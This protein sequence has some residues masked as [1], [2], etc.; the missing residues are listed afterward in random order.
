MEECI[1]DYIT[2]HVECEFNKNS[3]LL[4]IFF[5]VLF[6][7]SIA[8]QTVPPLLFQKITANAVWRRAFFTIQHCMLNA[9]STKTHSSGVN[10]YLPFQKRVK[11]CLSQQHTIRHILQFGL[12]RRHIFEA[13]SV[14]HQLTYLTILLLG[15]TLSDSDG[16]H[17][18]R[19]RTTDYAWDSKANVLIKMLK[20]GQKYIFVSFVS[21]QISLIL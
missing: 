2:L 1:F 17:P 7:F 3:L 19:L 14:T 20:K 10:F 16:R 8:G 13:Y 11:Q 4:V 5:S 18:S 6:T 21:F 15:D 9:N 12:G